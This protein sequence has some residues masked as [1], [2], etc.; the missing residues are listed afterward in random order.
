M[1]QC[2]ICLHEIMSFSRIQLV[3][4]ATLENPISLVLNVYKVDTIKYYKVFIIK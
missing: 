3:L 4:N 2:I 1:N